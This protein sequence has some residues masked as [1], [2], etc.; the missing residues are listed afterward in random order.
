MIAEAVATDY[1]ELI[2]KLPENGILTLHGVSWE[3]FENLVQAVGEAP[4]L[5]IAYD[6]GKMQIMTISFKHE[7][8]ACVLN[9][10]VDRLKHNFRIK[11]VFFGAATLKRNPRGIE[12]DA[13]FYVQ[14][15]SIIGNKINLDLRL[16]PPPD[17][18][19]EVDIHHE[20]FSRFHIYEGL[21]V[22]ELWHYD[23]QKLT[24]YHLQEE[25]YEAVTQSLA[26]PILTDEVLTKFLAQSQNEGQDET[27]LAFEE[28]LRGQK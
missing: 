20:S 17:V 6:Q 3:E 10:L 8:Y 23:E 27:L 12:P 25:R 4:N 16:D 24:I 28:W 19:L 13:C 9:R 26:F 11:T 21:G 5:R 2:E 7:Y 14:S 15:T 18:V 22:P 1:L